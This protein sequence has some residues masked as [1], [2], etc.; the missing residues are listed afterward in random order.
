M[1]CGDI[2]IYM[3][4]GYRD[5]RHNT[6]IISCLIYQESENDLMT[7]SNI[8][9]TKPNKQTRINKQKKKL[10]DSLTVFIFSYAI[11]FATIRWCMLENWT[12]VI[13]IIKYSVHIKIHKPDSPTFFRRLV[14]VFLS[15]SCFNEH[16]FVL[17]NRLCFIFLM[18]ILR[19]KHKK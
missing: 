2:H 19:I 7:H 17:F 11:I 8:I 5:M 18:I 15:S 9:I 4:S 1:V 16:I 10:S 13:K 14:W 6:N 12:C 3:R